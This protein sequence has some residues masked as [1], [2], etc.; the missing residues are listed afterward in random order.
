MHF[1]FDTDKKIDFK[2]KEGVMHFCFDT[3]NFCFDTKIF[4]TPLLIKTFFKANSI[5]N[6]YY[7]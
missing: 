3:G 1:C 5:S 6:I 4:I 7:Y 2:H